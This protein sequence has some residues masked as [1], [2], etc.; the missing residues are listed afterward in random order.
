VYNI[1]QFDV[2]FTCLPWPALQMPITY[3][4]LKSNSQIQ[5]QR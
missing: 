2:V 3:E 1:S 5:F 4:S